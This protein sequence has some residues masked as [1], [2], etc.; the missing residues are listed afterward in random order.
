VT[1]LLTFAILTLP[2]VGVFALAAALDAA[3]ERWQAD[4]LPGVYGREGDES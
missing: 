3:L 4:V 2:V 1:D